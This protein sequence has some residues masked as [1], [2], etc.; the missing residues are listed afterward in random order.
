MVGL[1]VAVA[2]VSGRGFSSMLR[3]G[4]V[5]LTE[6]PPGVLVSLDGVVL[7]AAIYYPLLLLIF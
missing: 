2:L 7:G 6:R 3:R 5:T 1:G 4:R